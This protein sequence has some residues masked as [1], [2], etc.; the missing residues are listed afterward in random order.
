N[1]VLRQAGLLAVRDGPFG[2]M[3]IP[4][5]S[6]AFAVA[7]HQIAHVYLNDESAESAV[8]ELLEATAGVDSVRHRKELQ[9]DH[10][11]SGHLIALADAD[12]WFTYYYW[13]DERRAPD[14][15][16]T[17]DI[18]RKPGYDPC[19]LFM[20]SKMRAGLRLLQKKIGMRYK[21]DVIPLDASLVRGS[22]GLRPDPMDGPLLIGPSDRMTLPKE[23][24]GFFDYMRAEFLSAS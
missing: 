19:E 13:N 20:T 18:H 6:R 8:R 9:L 3:L 5:Q 21:M 1:R 4:G 22:H 7:D 24:T 10:P 14:F 11:R 23:M 15:A 16:R 17:V 12:A 2:E